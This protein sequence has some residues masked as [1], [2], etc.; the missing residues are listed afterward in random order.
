MVLCRPYISGFRHFISL[1]VPFLLHLLFVLCPFLYFITPYS[2][3]TVRIPQRDRVS[4][5]VLYIF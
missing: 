1:Y 3:I 5:N 2:L 4:V